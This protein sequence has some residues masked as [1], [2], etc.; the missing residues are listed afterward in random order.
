MKE[1][2]FDEINRRIKRLQAEIEIAEENLRR[3][4]ELGGRAKGPKVKDYSPYYL[5]GM[6][7]WFTIGLVVIVFISKRSPSGVTIPTGL[8]AM[9]IVAFSVPLI[10]YLMTRKKKEEPERDFLERER[11]ARL[12]LKA[13]YEPLK[14]AVESDDRKALETLADELLNNP[15]LASAIERLG[16]GNPKL[17]AYGLLLY[18]R[19]EENLV[20]EVR[21]TIARLHNKPVKA[22]LTTLLDLS[23]KGYNVK[24]VSD[25]GEED[26]VRG[27]N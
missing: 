6:L 22:L 8:Y 27:A 21:E 3:I 2:V 25:T 7:L 9:M 17:M 13:F 20:E 23:R 5:A 19:F 15:S 11:M 18:A 1:E 26:E 14:R 12:V 24:G 16:E 10:Y 4:E